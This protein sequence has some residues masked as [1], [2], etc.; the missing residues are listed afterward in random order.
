MTDFDLR[1]SASGSAWPLSM[2]GPDTAA[3]N[4]Q[5][6]GS[7]GPTGPAGSYTAGQGITIQNGS[8]DVKA[9]P[10]N[11][12]LIDNWYFPNPV[13]QRAQASYSGNWAASIDR[14][15]CY[16]VTYNV[17]SHTVT[18]NESSGGNDPSLFQTI[19]GH[20]PGVVTL[21]ALINSELF[22]VTTSKTNNSTVATSVGWMGLWWLEN[23]NTQIQIAFSELA[24]GES[25]V[26]TAVKLEL[27]TQQTLAHQDASGN[28]VLNAVP[29]YAEQLMKCRRYY[30]TGVAN[31][32]LSQADVPG[33][34]SIYAATTQLSP[35]MRVASSVTY[36]G[37]ISWTLGEAVTATRLFNTYTTM[38]PGVALSSTPDNVLMAYFAASAEL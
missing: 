20:P 26:I 18:R 2:Q 24:V 13:N 15:F 6:Q 21:S 12:N 23:G 16:D 38:L 17:P 9:Y 34:G 29:N 36:S 33:Y 32:V 31:F 10:N 37:L 28:W 5:P 14:W 19:E 22:S 27:G 35:P 30:Q 1:F 8:I 25:A 4:W 7:P 3:L 11:P